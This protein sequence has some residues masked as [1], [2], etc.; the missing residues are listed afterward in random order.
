MPRIIN[1]DKFES[2]LLRVIVKA[3][4][5]ISIE[6]FTEVMNGFKNEYGYNESFNADGFP[7]GKKVSWKK[8]GLT[9][10]SKKYVHRKFKSGG[11]GGKY[12]P[13]LVRTGLLKKSIKLNFTNDGLD[14]NIEVVGDREK[15]SEY[16]SDRPHINEPGYL[17]KE[18]GRAKSVVRE[19]IRDEFK[20]MVDEG[21]IHPV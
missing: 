2:R 5:Q 1:R 11:R 4:K 15:I 7:N 6:S 9:L 20:K 10:G 13:I 18:G 12:S 3:I 17:Y 21:I 8:L 14:V 16:N 19:A